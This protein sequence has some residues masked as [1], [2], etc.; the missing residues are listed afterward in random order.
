MSEVNQDTSC[1]LGGHRWDLEYPPSALR[2]LQMQCGDLPSLAVSIA[3]QAM[4]AGLKDD[5][6][7]LL[8]WAGQ[9]HAEPK[10]KRSWVKR[11]LEAVDPRI[12]RILLAW[13]GAEFCKAVLD[14]A[15]AQLATALPYP[16]E[17]DD[18]E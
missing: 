3:S 1:V 2:A 11:F 15:A 13:A 16:P 12:K 14:I 18:D 5:L 9:K 7:V 4:G 10:L 17:E 8:V 6:A